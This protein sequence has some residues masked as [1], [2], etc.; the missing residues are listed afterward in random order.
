MKRT[1]YCFAGSWGIGWTLGGL[2][3]GNFL[4]RPGDVLF[5]VLFSVVGII[6]TI[7]YIREVRHE[8]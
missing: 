8:V 3:A 2:L 5:D 6:F 4:H 1:L 7:L